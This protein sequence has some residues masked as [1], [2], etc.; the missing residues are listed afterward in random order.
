MNIAIFDP[1]V[2]MT[3]GVVVF[4]ARLAIPDKD[5]N[6]KF[7]YNKTFRRADI[8]FT[9]I[10]ATFDRS[11][12]RIRLLCDATPKQPF[13][14][15]DQPFGMTAP[16]H[17]ATMRLSVEVKLD[18]PRG[19]LSPQKVTT[20]EIIEM[21]DYWASNDKGKLGA[22]DGTIVTVNNIKQSHE[23]YNTVYN[24]LK[25]YYKANGCPAKVD[26][27][28]LPE[29]LKDYT[30]ELRESWR[31]E[32]HNFT[33]PA[34]GLATCMVD[35][36][37]GRRMLELTFDKLLEWKLI[38]GY[39][40]ITQASCRA[41]QWDSLRETQFVGIY[42]SMG[43]GAN[44]KNAQLVLKLSHIL[45]RQVTLQ[46]LHDGLTRIVESTCTMSS[47]MQPY[48]TFADQN[49]KLFVVGVTKTTKREEI[50]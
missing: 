13:M 16:E 3:D 21:P 10:S 37:A 8:E 40:T 29:V 42:V 15:K 25:A 31:I 11:A 26:R 18:I 19:A 24:W 27:R 22:A 49:T 47:Q 36:L 9:F 50:K 46:E 12:N 41:K 48:I 23:I 30:K 45:G 34:N 32:Q 43:K 35:A 14:P 39:P 1:E 28:K 7:K 33:Y 44:T 2:A 17:E 20:Y 38:P 4:P 6:T 5:S